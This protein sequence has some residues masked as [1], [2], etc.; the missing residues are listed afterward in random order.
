MS[1]AVRTVPW[2][3]FTGAVWFQTL[4]S[5]ARLYYSICTQ[6]K[7]GDFQ[8]TSLSLLSTLSHIP[9]RRKTKISTT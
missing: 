4:S 6:N 5:R 8:E 3:Y 9:R 2:F 7:A 1:V